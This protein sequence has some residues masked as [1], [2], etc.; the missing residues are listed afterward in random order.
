MVPHRAKLDA[1]TAGNDF[2][3]EFVPDAQLELAASQQAPPKHP[4]HDA[5]PLEAE[6]TRAHAF[7]MAQRDT[8]LTVDLALKK[9][10]HAPYI[11]ASAQS[12]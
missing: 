9:A 7:A 1:I 6:H 10:L 4:K 2:E 3:F 8:E 5:I 12:T 11:V